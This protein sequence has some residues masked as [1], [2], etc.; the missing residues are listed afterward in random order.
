M[1]G[2]PD[3]SPSYTVMRS[4]IKEFIFRLNRY[5]L[6]EKANRATLLPL[7]QARNHS[8]YYSV[9]LLVQANILSLPPKHFGDKETDTKKA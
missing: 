7:T 9:F 5:F 3:A 8:I 2:P 4:Q 1:E 6:Q